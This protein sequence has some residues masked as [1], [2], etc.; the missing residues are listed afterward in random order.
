VAFK[1]ALPALIAGAIPAATGAL[2]ASKA[3]AV[4]TVAVQAV[5]AVLTVKGSLGFGSAALVAG[6]VFWLMSRAPSG[7]LPASDA[8]PAAF[9]ASDGTG[10][11]DVPASG[12]LRPSE[13]PGREREALVFLPDVPETAGVVSGSLENV[14]GGAVSLRELLDRLGHGR[15]GLPARDR[16][17]LRQSQAER[18]PVDYS[19]MFEQYLRNLSDDAVA[20]PADPEPRVISLKH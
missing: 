6:G 4:L 2:L 1:A 20:E 17:P 15:R 18:C 12:I 7:V 16:K 11:F 14:A 5:R 3:A 8:A 9:A 13:A 10:A 19:G